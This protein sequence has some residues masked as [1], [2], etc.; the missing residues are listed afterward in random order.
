FGVLL[1]ALAVHLRKKLLPI[2]QPLPNRLRHFQ[3]TAFG[4]VLLTTLSL[5]VA[6]VQKIPLFSPLLPPLSAVLAGLGFYAA[7]VAYMWPRWRRAV[8]RRARVV[9]L[10]MPAN[11]LECAWWIAVAVL[12]GV[13]EEITWRGVQGALVGVVTGNFWIAAL[14]CSISFGLTHI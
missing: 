13:G 1:P 5:L 14:F 12:A 9:H 3:K 6:W 11:A 10:D 4:I 2:D 7:A 8:E